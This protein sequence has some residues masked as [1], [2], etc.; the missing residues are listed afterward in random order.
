MHSTHFVHILFAV[1]DLNHLMVGFAGTCLEVAE[2]AEE[3]GD[4]GPPPCC[5]S[6]L[7]VI[8]IEH[9]TSC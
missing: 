4:G 2:P 8:V 5:P 3:A 1:G 6:Q 9:Y 7:P